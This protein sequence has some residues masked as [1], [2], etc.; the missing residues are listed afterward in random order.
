MYDAV[1]ALIVSI[2]CEMTKCS[3]D[4]F[5]CI[6]T[7]CD[8]LFAYTYSVLVQEVTKSPSS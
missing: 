2:R 7:P 4:Y 3:H 1:A 5:D 6:E 8:P